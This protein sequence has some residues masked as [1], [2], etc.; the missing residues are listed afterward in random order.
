MLNTTSCS[1]R[2]GRSLAGMFLLATAFG[3]GDDVSLGNY[4]DTDSGSQGEVDNETEGDTTGATSCEAEGRCDP[5]F[6]VAS[7]RGLSPLGWGIDVAANAL[8]TDGACP[9]EQAEVE[10]QTFCL[11]SEAALASTVGAEEYCRFSAGWLAEDIGVAFA[12][13]LDPDSV[14]RHRASPLDES[15]SEPYAWA[16]GSVELRGPGTAYRGVASGS[17]PQ[18]INEACAERLTEQGIEWTD[19]ELEGLCEGTW[20][21][22]GVLRPLRMRAEMVFRPYDGVLSSTSG[23]SCSSPE[24]GADTCCTACD[25]ALGPKIAR[26]GVDTAG[27]RRTVA[28]GTAIA[29]D[30]DGDRMV[31]C[32][33][34]V[35]HVD[36][37]ED[38]P[39]TYAWDGAPES[40]PIPRPDKLRET[41][42]TDRPPGL[43]PEGPACETHDDCESGQRCFGV[44]P[45]GNACTT[46]EGCAQR[47]CQPSW[48]GECASLET[49]DFC[50]D[51]R[52]DARGAGACMQHADQPTV[53][54][55]EC[56][57]ASGNL[58]S[59]AC[60]DPALGGASGCDPFEQPGLAVA[61]RYDRDP[62]LQ[63][64]A[65]CACEDGQPELCVPHIEDWCAPPLGNGES[66]E[67]GA[68]AVPLV[69]RPGGVAIADEGHL[70]VRLATRGDLARGLT[71]ECAQS[72]GRIDDRSPADGWIE[73]ASFRAE[74][75]E[76]H[77]LALCSGSTY[78]LSFAPS[79]EVD[80]LRSADGGTL[81][82]RR[83]FRI[84]TGQ[85]RLHERSLF[86]TDNLR[87]S[88]CD[89]FEVRF[90]NTPD[91]GSRNL[92]KVALREGAPDGPVVA[93]GPDCSETATPEDVANGAI[94]CLNTRGDLLISAVNFYVDEAIHGPVLQ[95]DVTYFVVVPELDD[96]S[97]MADDDAYA[98]AFHDVCGMPLVHTPLPEDYG[99]TWM[100]FTV[101]EACGG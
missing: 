35:L 53:R 10:G 61:P 50:V 100:Q 5:D 29:C 20:D 70:S 3:C 85:F 31:E 79:D 26:Y 37:D 80:S 65:G 4:G 12:T 6:A 48:F 78:E 24:T 11:G 66:S 81:D 94:P 84:E 96:I 13:P 39:Y 16:V 97:Q 90:S 74:L 75:Q 47:T 76:D 38:T 19:A 92:S 18:A 40:W 27:E 2:K 77:D 91:F 43:V 56:S 23:N 55:S 7:I 69:T 15:T 25:L 72:R 22:G 89:D 46:A 86:P 101:D 88:S 54:L 68:Y 58:T 36:R 51:R 41:H 67:P 17:S 83:T 1:K 52:F 99:P 45:D 28:A 82:G 98:A 57:D 9:T 14:A 30:P 32:R 33:D 49:G 59:A 93:G 44:L 62:G 95:P 60:C 87:I 64:V 73:Y 71:E 42:P 34:L 8:C 63:G 21:D